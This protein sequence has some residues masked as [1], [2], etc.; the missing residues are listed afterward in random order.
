MQYLETT[1]QQFMQSDNGSYSRLA[2][3]LNKLAPR[4]DGSRW[5]K[6]RLPLLPNTR[7]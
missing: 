7:H 6:L 4:S 2:D 5:T 1:A 3:L